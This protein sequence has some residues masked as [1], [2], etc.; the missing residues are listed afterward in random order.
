MP[1]IVSTPLP[2]REL[3]LLQRL[4]QSGGSLI[5]GREKEERVREGE[6]QRHISIERVDGVLRVWLKDIRH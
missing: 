4:G 5:F 3:T 6:I 2:H 1:F